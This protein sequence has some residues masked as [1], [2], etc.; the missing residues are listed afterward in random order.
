MCITYKSCFAASLYILRRR[1][2]YGPIGT[3]HWDRQCSHLYLAVPKWADR[4]GPFPLDQCGSQ[5]LM[6]RGPLVDWRRWWRTLFAVRGK[7]SWGNQFVERRFMDKLF[8]RHC[9]VS[10]T[11]RF[12]ETSTCSFHRQTLQC[13]VEKETFISGFDWC[14]KASKTCV[15]EPLT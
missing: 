14:D 11:N 9:N 3:A 10:S 5:P 6:F 4:M 2:W 13:F 8:S 15:W 12:V 7:E 1:L